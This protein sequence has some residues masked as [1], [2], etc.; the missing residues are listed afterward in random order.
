MNLDKLILQPVILRDFFKEGKSGSTMTNRM[1]SM[2]ISDPYQMAFHVKVI[3]YKFAL[4][5]FLHF[6]TSYRYVHTNVKEM[7][8]S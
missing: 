8:P 6:S 3:F 5:V 4:L 2:S 1:K 7:S